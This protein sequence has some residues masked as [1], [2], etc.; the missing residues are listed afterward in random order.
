MSEH[1]KDPSS[2]DEPHLAP[3]EIQSDSEVIGDM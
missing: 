2:I 1:I 3:E